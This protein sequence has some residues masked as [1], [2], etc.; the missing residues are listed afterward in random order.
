MLKCYLFTF[1]NN[2]E[3][4]ILKF[5]LYFN[6]QY[7]KL[8]FTEFPQSNHIKVQIMALIKFTSQKADAVQ[9]SPKNPSKK[10]N[11]CYIYLIFTENTTNKG[12]FKY[13]GLT[14]SESN[15]N[16]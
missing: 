8:F 4:L 10:V 16:E 15:T 9:N 3:L 13:F 14:V 2:F 7:E 12:F 6:F 1:K 5:T 11:V